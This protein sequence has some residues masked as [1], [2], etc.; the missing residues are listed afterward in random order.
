MRNRVFISLFL[1][2][3]L[4]GCGTIKG[5]FTKGKNTSAEEKSRT[6]VSNV[7]QAIVNNDRD[8]LD[9]LSNL[10]Y[11]VGYALNKIDNPSKEVNVAK[12]LNDRA[13]SI[14]GAP[15]LEEMQKMKKLIDDLTSQLATEREHGQ[16]ELQDRDQQIKQLQSEAKS[17]ADAKD[18]EIR[19][20]MQIAQTTAE[21]ADVYKGTLDKMNSYLGLGAVFYG[22]KRFFISSA[23]ILGIFSVLFLVLR[24][25][26]N[27]N[28]IAKAVFSIFETILSWFV[29]LI[30]GLAPKAVELANYTPNVI[31]DAYKKTLYKLIDCIETIRQKQ[32]ELVQDAVAANKPVETYTVD[33]LMED[34][35]KTMGDSDKKLITDIKHELGYLN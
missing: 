32:K 27:T 18:N 19:K 9:E 30:K 17:L 2:V 15:T 3:L 5:V 20:Y 23:W 16:Q 25:A 34:V 24:F 26:S 31:V 13:Q 12:D 22:L 35:A 11:G 28:P 21:K 14:T 33:E 6:K 4:T 7:E 10:T 8:K 29:H 1:I